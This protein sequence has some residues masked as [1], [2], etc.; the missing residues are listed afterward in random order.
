MIEDAK[1]AIVEADVPWDD[2]RERR[3]LSRVER[4][5][6][7]ARSERHVQERPRWRAV[8]W[9]AGTLAAATLLAVATAT[10]I[11]ARTGDPVTAKAAF[12]AHGLAHVTD[13]VFPTLALADGSIA[14][15]REAAR[16]D[17]D[18]QTSDLVRLLQH[19]GIV[20]YDVAKNASRRFVI[21][22]QGIEVRVIGTSFT[23]E[24]EP[25]HVRVSVE[26][27]RVAVEGSQ[28]AAE[29]GA[30][31]EIRLEIEP[32]ETLVILDDDPAPSPATASSGDD[33]SPRAKT[34]P[35][36]TVAQLLARADAARSQGRLA[37]AAATLGELVREHPQDPR[38][39]SSYFLL[40]KVERARGHHGAA[41][42]AFAACSRRA[43][44]G[45]L[46]EDARA[47]AAASWLD[48]GQTARAAKDAR[49]Y[50]EL[51]PKGAHADR[52]RRILDSVQ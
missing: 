9:V 8:A 26:R 15:L 38:A 29:L 18:V 31:D 35:T 21:D 10:A 5:L 28:T 41:A 4:A 17:V 7:E 45:S 22:A 33:R 3:V 19:S 32:E 52:M 42:S 25:S 51:H 13:P 48:A 12:A 36:A 11:G 44:A 47:E 39:Y 14:H 23:V 16:V 46:S 37:E 50:L 20:R 43:P 1:R 6:A 30:G 49:T 24:V 34:R 27:G 2:L 40:G